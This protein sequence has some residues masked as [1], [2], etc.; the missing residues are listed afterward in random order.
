MRIIIVEDNQQDAKL[1][2]K[3]LHRSGYGG[4]EKVFTDGES[5]ILEVEHHAETRSTCY[6]KGVALVLL[7]LNLPGMSGLDLL[8]YLRD[9]ACFKYT[10]VVM[11]TSESDAEVIRACYKAGANSFIHK[12][13]DFGDFI[14]TIGQ[15]AD[16]WIGVNEIVEK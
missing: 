14:A 9:T 2:V 11:L 10:P 5:L 4:A 1:T 15:A 3:A 8:C 6:S 16:Y 12:E 7:D 13:V